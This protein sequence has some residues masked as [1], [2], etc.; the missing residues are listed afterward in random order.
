MASNAPPLTGRGL[1]DGADANSRTQLQT[2]SGEPLFM[3]RAARVRLW[4]S[5]AALCLA[6]GATYVVPGL[7]AAQPWATDEDY[8]PFWNVIGREWMSQEASVKE[9]T[10][11][12]DELAALAKR[13]NRPAPKT[14]APADSPTS[15]PRLKE[16]LPDAGNAEES[17]PRAVA[18]TYPA[19]EPG[20]A[21]LAAEVTPI[22]FSQALDY[23]YSHL[24]LTELE[25][26]GA[27]TRAGHWGDSALGN[28]GIT[29]AIRRRLQE[30][31]GDA[32]HGFH[33]LAQ[34]N[35]GYLHQGVRFKD[36][37]GWHKCQIIFK[38]EKDGLYGYGGVSAYSPGGGTSFWGTT[39]RGFGSSVSRFELWYLEQPRGGKFQ[40]K[41]DG[42]VDRVVNTEGPE[43]R[44]GWARIDVPDGP[45]EFEV[46]A[47]GDG[48]ARGF[49]VVLER[50]VPGVVW[51]ELSLIGSF[52]QRLDYQEPHHIAEQIHFR[53][54]DM[55]VFLLGGNDVQR[56][57]MDLY[58]TMQPYEEEY[59]RVIRKF[60]AGKPE[61]SC[62]IMSLT[63]HGERVGRHEIRTRRI[64]PKLVAS[65]RKVAEL[66]GCAFFN[67]FEAMGG[68]G[69]IARWYRAK[70]ALAGGDLAHATSAGHEVIG[71][72]FVQSLLHG[73]AQFRRR[74]EGKPLPTL[75]P[76]STSASD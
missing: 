39:K 54:N 40:I 23:Y 21:E 9:Q 12:L 73:Y 59:Q 74:M 41:V 7:E 67:T 15:H 44:S 53:D 22:E 18:E 37:G 49:G 24:T 70:P 10:A 28:D 34:Y 50:D 75:E 13:A 57:K 11:D 43:V 1:L 65:Q 68:E 63:D 60:R 14:H 45:H 72:L 29:S 32:G 58:R 36:Q 61:A 66:E 2:Q 3:S 62:L 16:Q 30:R 35:L 76:R 25:K 46:R 71:E 26:P 42:R 38:C 64:V 20:D 56:E 55:L 8:V 47:I 6:L 27:V 31:F 33:V 69:S 4:S 5:A 48:V 19:Y 51:D 52:T 17:V